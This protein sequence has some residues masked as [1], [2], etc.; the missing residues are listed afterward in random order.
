MS[1]I[2]SI[3]VSIHGAEDFPKARIDQL[4][5]WLE[6]YGHKTFLQ[7]EEDG[8]G[9]KSFVCF[10][11]IGTFNHFET[12]AFADYL[13]SI[14]WTDSAWTGECHVQMLVMEFDRNDVYTWKIYPLPWPENPENPL[15][16]TQQ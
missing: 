12:D 15:L 6:Q 7:T 4:N 11:L 9:E 13:V 3:I 14:P 16:E 10:L 2:T 5:D 1:I 8:G